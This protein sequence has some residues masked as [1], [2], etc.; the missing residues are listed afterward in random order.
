M[1]RRRRQVPSV[2]TPPRDR[3]PTSPAASP[4]APAGVWNGTRRSRY[5]L[6]LVLF[7]LLGTVW[8]VGSYCLFRSFGNRAGPKEPAGPDV[9]ALVRVQAKP[10][11][12]LADGPAANS[13]SF[14]DY[15]RSQVAL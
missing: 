8:V 12:M 4:A 10:P 1:P 6:L 11:R 7:A 15:R 13:E 2:T 5:P 14:E 9:Y 3:P